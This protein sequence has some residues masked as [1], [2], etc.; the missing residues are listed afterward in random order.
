M[1]LS[2]SYSSFFF[3][4]WSSIRDVLNLIFV[5]DFMGSPAMNLIEAKTKKEKNYIKIEIKLEDGS[6]ASLKE[7]K[8]LNLPKD[9]IV[10]VKFQ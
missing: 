4:S 3:K 1:M 9:I 2:I 6:I 8:N 5:A 7:T 10:G